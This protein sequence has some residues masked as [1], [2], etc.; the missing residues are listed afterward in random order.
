MD[1]YTVK[2]WV[3]TTKPEPFGEPINGKQAT[4]SQGHYVEKQAV[5][6][7]DVIAFLKH[8]APNY[9]EH[10]QLR[11]NSSKEMVTKHDQ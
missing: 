11:L 7:E 3:T 4:I 8:W 5:L 2:E 1:T 10:F 6:V 9:V